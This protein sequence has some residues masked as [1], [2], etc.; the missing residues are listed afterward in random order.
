[1]TTDAEILERQ[2]KPGWLLPYLI[3]LD[4]ITNADPDTG[5][6]PPDRPGNMRWAYWLWV[7]EHNA[8][9][10]EP[11]PQLEFANRPKPPAAKAVKSW[12]SYSLSH[13]GWSYDRGWLHLVR[14][15]LFGFGMEQLSDDVERIPED[16]RV[17]WYRQVNLH[18]LLANP[19]DWSAF[20]LQGGLDNS[21]ASRWAKSSGFFSTPMNI[22]KA[23]AMMSI[24][25]IGG[26]VDFRSQSVYDPCCGTGTML[27]AAS[28]YSLVLFGQDIVYDLV[29][30]TVLNGYL[31]MPWLVWMPEEC[32]QVLADHRRR[33]DLLSVVHALVAG[34]PPEARQAA[35]EIVTGVEVSDNPTTRKL[36]EDRRLQADEFYAAVQRGK[37]DQFAL[38]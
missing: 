10:P 16:V 11:I 27:L 3:A 29:L 8:L 6:L 1:V 17:F 25:M 14:W 9:P 19:C 35:Q 4:A 22:A 20:I 12:L 5:E 37:L 28:N 31:Y 38:W 23:M 32:H 34:G 13:Y 15:M 36:A 24:P 33:V 18:V 26:V 21:G 2:G 7:Y 30:C